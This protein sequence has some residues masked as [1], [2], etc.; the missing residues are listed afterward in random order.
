MKKFLTSLWEVAKLVIIALLI[1][2]PIRYFIF[3]PFI[4]KGQ[5]M[6]PNFA[7]GDY[8]I[9]DE[10]SYRFQAPQ[11][12]DVIVFKYPQDPTQR[13]I[14]RIIGLPGETVE[15]I[16]GK[17][18]IFHGATEI[19]T[20][21]EL[22]YI[23]PYLPTEGD[24]RMVLNNNEYF[25]L[26]DNRLASYDSR[27]WGPLPEKNIIGRVLIRAWPITALAEIKDPAY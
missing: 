14:K 24:I 21:N 2:I 9:V 4:V 11:R 19:K 27:R 6:E 22:S 13:Y 5:S 18:T 16:N 10:I 12:G 8:L 15:I 26:G 1:V 7:N 17:I 23:P 20:L 3:Q 25:V